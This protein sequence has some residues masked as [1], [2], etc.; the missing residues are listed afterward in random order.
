[1]NFHWMQSG[2]AVGAFGLAAGGAAPS[3]SRFL[4]RCASAAL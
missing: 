3:S 1:M 2:H 4:L